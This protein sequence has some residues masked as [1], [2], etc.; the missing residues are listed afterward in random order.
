MKRGGDRNKRWHGPPLL[1]FCNKVRIMPGQ[2]WEWTDSLRDGYGRFRVGG[3]YISAHVFA[4]ET[5]IGQVPEGKEV[6]PG[7]CYT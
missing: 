1:R 2:C 4:Y 3:H 7:A 6:H 5:F